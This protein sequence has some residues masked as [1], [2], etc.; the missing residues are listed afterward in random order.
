MDS[1]VKSAAD[2]RYQRLIIIILSV[3][4]AL[5]ILPFVLLVS[6]SFTDESTLVSQ[7]YSF[8][9]R[10]FQ[11]MPMNICLAPTALRFSEPMA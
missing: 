11:R 4:A 3:F 9:P 8:I 7:G 6:S 1:S 5:A 10:K 2:R